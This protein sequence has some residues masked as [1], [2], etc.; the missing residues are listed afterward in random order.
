MAAGT[1]AFGMPFCA[2]LRFHTLSQKQV[3]GNYSF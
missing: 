3:A 1:M 2:G